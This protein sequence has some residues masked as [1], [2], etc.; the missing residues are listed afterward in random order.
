MATKQFGMVIDN[1]RCI[2]CHTCSVACKVENNLPRGMWWN[3]TT[4]VGGDAP[5]SP[6]GTW[7]DVH[8]Q[9]YTI[10]CQH[11]ETPACVAV[12]P[13][14]ATYKREEDGVVIQD[15]E[16]CIGCKLCI[17]ACPYTGVRTFVGDIPEFYLDYPIGNSDA[18][19]H[20]EL[21]VEKCTMCVH[22]LDRGEKP[23]CIDACPAVARYFGDILDPLS[24]AAQL[25]ASRPHVQLQPEAGTN[26][27]IY[28]L[29]G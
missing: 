7:P 24:E 28:F 9:Y 3:K 27:S 29:E 23:A 8:R 17:E 15:N 13:A 19:K 22:R 11:C 5:D 18:P 20:A 14:E 4:T 6:S 1:N 2:G 21:Y 10:S 12:C 26:P 16:L 25:I